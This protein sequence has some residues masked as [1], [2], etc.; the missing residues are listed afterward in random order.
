MSVIFIFSISGHPLELS[1]K[2]WACCVALMATGSCLL[3]EH[4]VSVASRQRKRDGAR[5]VSPG[6]PIRDHES[7]AAAG[8]R[9]DHG[10]RNAARARRIASRRPH[11]RIG[12]LG[13][14]KTMAFTTLTMFQLY[15]VFNARSA[16]R[17]AFAGLLANRWL[18]AQAS[19]CRSCCTWPLFTYFSCRRR[20]RRQA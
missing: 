16:E 19:G 3:M 2:P 18:W 1:F 17:S 15:N 11:R 8:R 10:G 20:S 4:V 6:K 5:V 9:G 7:A 13:Y 14:G 12:T